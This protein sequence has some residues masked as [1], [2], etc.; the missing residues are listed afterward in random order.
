M[1]GMTGYIFSHVDVLLGLLLLLLGLIKLVN[2]ARFL[3]KC[4]MAQATIIDQ[5]V[6]TE[7]GDEGVSHRAVLTLRFFDAKGNEHSVVVGQSRFEMPIPHQYPGYED[8]RVGQVVE[9]LYDPEHPDVNVKLNT[10]L[11]VYGVNGVLLFGGA[12]ILFI[13]FFMPHVV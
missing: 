8:T 7:H 4:Q 5:A 11:Q 10:D 2:V 9:V 1:V 13:H 6:Y 3:R 12:V